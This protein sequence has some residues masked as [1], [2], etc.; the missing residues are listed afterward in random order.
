MKLND[1]ADVAGPALFGGWPKR[2]GV[3][4]TAL[5]AVGLAGACVVPFVPVWPCILFEHFRV[6]Y[7]AG[8]L[9]IV[10]CAAALGMRGYF[11]AAVTATLVNVLWIAPDLCGSPR[12]IPS[13]GA[14]IR[15][16]ASTSLPYRCCNQHSSIDV[17]ISRCCVQCS[18]GAVSRLRT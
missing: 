18:A 8:G 3:A 15:M 16:A 5:A 9:A 12:L 17:H 4:A 14:P 13:D 1:P 11:D 2:L 7:A 6:Q 10:A